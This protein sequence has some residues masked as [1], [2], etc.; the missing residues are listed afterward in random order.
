MLEVQLVA[1]L[2]PEKKFDDLDA[3]RA[4]MADDCLAAR[5]ILAAAEPAVAVR[6]GGL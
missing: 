5:R 6:A 4:Q 2:R 3:L 1:R